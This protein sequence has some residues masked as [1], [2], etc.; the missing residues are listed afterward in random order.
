[1]GYYA[2]AA[3]LS[4]FMLFQIEPMMG[5]YIL[6]W[7]GGTPAVW[8]TTMLFFQ[9][10]LTGGYGYAHWLV[11]RLSERRQA[12]VHTTML[13]VSL[14]LLAVTTIAWNAPI[15]PDSS[16]KPA[17]VE[18]PIADIFKILAVA[19]G[20]PFFLLS[21]NGPLVQAWFNR[22]YPGRS[23]YRLYALSNA[24]SL[25]A[26]VCYPVLVEPNM[27]LRSQGW[28]WSAG[29]VVFAILSFYGAWKHK[30]SKDAFSPPGPVEQDGT[31]PGTR[32]RFV[33]IA[34]AGCASV[35]LLATT[36]QLT[37]E[38]AVIPF[39]WVLPL[40]IYLLTFILCFD[41]DRWYSRTKFTVA[42]VGAIVLYC[43]VRT[44]GAS[45]GVIVQ[46]GAY[47]VV[48]FIAC[49]ICHGELTHLKPHPRY[50]TSFYFMVSLG[51]AVGGIAVSLIAP[52]VFKEYWELPLGLLACAVLLLI[53]TL[54]NRL[55][56]QSARVTRN[57]A[58]VLA[59]AIA[60]LAGFFFVYV[61]ATM[62]GALYVSRNFYGVLRVNEINAE[63]PE[64]RAFRLA[65]GMT[66][67]GLQY[68]GNDKRRLPTT[69]FTESSGIGL[70]ILNHP[71]RPAPLRIG[72]LGLGIGTLAAFGQPGDV[73]RFYEINP[74]VIQLAEG[75]GG[76]FT[77]V[78]DSPARVEIVPGDARISLEREWA[79]GQAQKFDLLV[80]DT[81]NGDSIPIHLVTQQALQVYL[82]HLKP[83]GILA[84]HISNLHLDLRPVLWRLADE[85]HL[86]ANFIETRGEPGRGY[87][88]SWMLLTQN[89][90]FLQ[91]PGIA[92]RSIPHP[93]NA[94]AVF[95]LWTDD[96]SNLFQILR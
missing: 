59:G 39:L 86:S 7:F 16:W 92:S 43:Y 78:K 11:A 6:P 2:V 61:Q 22:A 20:L 58:T 88:S 76:Y 49:M 30:G 12:V 73:I 68:E 41:S 84:M 66:N 80:V 53:L 23:P 33:W 21:T 31:A 90:V 71:R 57:F 1:M 26:L 75:K 15:T 67:H 87:L 63:L 81:F 77:Y 4:A 10:A 27:S 60:L 85:F 74:D 40:I 17:S 14:L 8:T 18:M 62:G 64:E 13:G 95:P 35:L 65:Q 37:Q 55:P 36:S 45:L 69:Y 54:V 28:F 91:Q 70:A 83:D 79:A 25:L 93:A 47:C 9:V 56:S 72:V 24:G 3:F 44:M 50:L 5:K 19:I 38:V 42:F 96:Y 52:Y 48:L 32:I 89:Q 46:I 51:G 82:Q 34:L 29:Y 94:A